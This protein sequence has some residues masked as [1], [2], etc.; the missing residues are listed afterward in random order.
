MH[1]TGKTTKEGELHYQ[2]KW[3]DHAYLAEVSETDGPLLCSETDIHIP[4]QTRT[5]VVGYMAAPLS[6]V[7]GWCAAGVSP[8]CVVCPVQVPAG[9]G[10]REALGGAATAQGQGRGQGGMAAAMAMAAAAAAARDEELLTGV[11]TE[12]RAARKLREK[13]LVRAVGRAGGHTTSS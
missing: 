12:V 7:C 3:V 6:A 9:K 13:Q 10:R 2:G 5:K 8:G 1:G 11:S 4:P